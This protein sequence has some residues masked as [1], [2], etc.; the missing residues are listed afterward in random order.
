MKRV[1]VLGSTGSIGESA[2]RVVEALPEQL[3][4]V[5]LAAESNIERLLEQAAQH[6]VTR[7]AVAD[8]AAAS[9]C[10]REAPGNIEVLAGDDGVAELAAMAEADIVLCAVV[11]VSGLRPV[12]R[13]LQ[14]G[15][16]VALA[17]KE[18]L[19]A[20]GQPVMAAAEENK[21]L[22]LPVDS[23]HN[24]IFQ[25][26]E[27]KPRE[28]IK[29]IVLT[30]SGGP[31]VQEETD[32]GKVSVDEALS[33]PRWNMGRKVTIDSATLM[34][35]GL[36]IME[37]HWLFGVPLDSIDVVIHPE[38]IIHS[39][40]EFVDGSMLAQLSLPDMRFAI[41]HT[42]TYPERMDGGLPTLN[43]V[44]A[45]ALHFQEPDQDRF[46]CLRLARQAAETGGT[47]P[48]VLSAANEVAVQMFLD[49]RISF[50]G[51]WETIETVLSKHSVTAD[52]TMD[53]VIA[54]DT[55][56]RKTTGE[57]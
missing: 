43:L 32:F 27:G 20:A 41:Q 38:S 44:E 25:C 37:A 33:H 15:T 42:L 14:A 12:M 29:R 45:G 52:P 35:K 1:V 13:A 48:A 50:S 2:L 19:V 40:V 23:E 54:A 34:N 46:P 28:S 26:I 3:Q 57:I 11:G 21:A 31:F 6:C 18:V 8:T 10:A 22:I 24:A 7:I 30:A 5:G 56:A 36:E 51:I 55:W 53:D 47:V 17:T 39:L 16:D 4:I 9:S 49:G